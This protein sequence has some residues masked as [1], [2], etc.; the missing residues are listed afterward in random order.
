[1]KSSVK[2]FES[3]IVGFITETHKFYP[4]IFE[5]FPAV[6]KRTKLG[7]LIS[8]VVFT[9]LSLLR[10]DWSS[11]GLRWKWHQISDKI[12][13]M[14]YFNKFIEELHLPRNVFDDR[15]EAIPLTCNYQ[16]QEKRE[17]KS[18]SGEDFDERFS[19]TNDTPML[20][21]GKGIYRVYKVHKN[22]PILLLSHIIDLEYSEVMTFDTIY[23][24]TKN[25]KTLE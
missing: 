16:W 11:K 13:S 3:L 2:S 20:I 5:N 8:A 17:L 18:L 12:E 6:V 24:L 23:Q 9:N 7:K 10:I 21:D 19:P 14:A 1:M 4:A 25:I 15:F 22:C